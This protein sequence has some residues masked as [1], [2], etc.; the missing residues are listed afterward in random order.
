MSD[1]IDPTIE[2][3]MKWSEP[4]IIILPRSKQTRSFGCPQDVIDWITEQ[5]NFWGKLSESRPAN[6]LRRQF[7]GL[8]RMTDGLIGT[9]KAQIEPIANDPISNL[10]AWRDKIE[11]LFDEIVSLKYIDAESSIAQALLAGMDAGRDTEIPFALAHIHRMTSDTLANVD[12]SI[13]ASGYLWGSELERDPVTIAS[14]EDR[15]NAAANRWEEKLSTVHNTY[16]DANVLLA[17]AEET[18]RTIQEEETKLWQKFDEESRDKIAALDK[19]LREKIQL[20][21][22]VEYWDK[23][24]NSHAESSQSFIRAFGVTLVVVLVASV[25]ALPKLVNARVQMLNEIAIS[26]YDTHTF[27]YLAM[28]F[29]VL[30]IAGLPILLAIWVLRFLMREIIEHSRLREDAN[31][32]ANMV[33][34]YLALITDVGDVDISKGWDQNIILDAIF[35][36]V[37]VSTSDD[38]WPVAE[39]LKALKGGS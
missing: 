17:N 24:A 29:S 13:V 16:T 20:D 26:L 30:A 37:A 28:S 34:V 4:I 6:N 7:K 5:E 35:R 36:P 2:L 10:E 22:A 33:K 18:A 27:E 12:P 9:L 15:V 1:G 19:T 31:M 21:A 38:G 25:F 11:T 3:H 8:K 32:R 39:A 23:K 14:D